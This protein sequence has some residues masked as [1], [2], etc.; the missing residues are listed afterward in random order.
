MSWKK[1][2]GKGQEDN[3]EGEDDNCQKDLEEGVDEG[4]PVLPEVAI[5]G[6]VANYGHD[7]E[8]VVEL[9]WLW[10]AREACRVC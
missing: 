1:A 9:W 6:N 3:Y 7:G 10:C 8:A 5:G 2:Y 4:R